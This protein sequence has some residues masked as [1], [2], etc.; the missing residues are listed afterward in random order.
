MIVLIER[1]AM[2]AIQ[3]ILWKSALAIVR[4]LFPL[5]SHPLLLLEPPFGLVYLS[6]PVIW[7][8]KNG[9]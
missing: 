8:L 5:L 6:L 4:G 9:D 1:F 7:G 3:H 2:A